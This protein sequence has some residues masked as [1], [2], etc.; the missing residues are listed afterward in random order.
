MG[1][2]TH[3]SFDDF[4]KR[5][6]PPANMLTNAE[7]DVDWDKERNEWLGYLDTLYATIAEFLQEYINDDS[8]R[9][10]F[11]QVTL[12]EEDIGSY[13]ARVMEIYIGRQEITLMP[14][15]TLFIGLKGRV[16][17][18]GSAGRSRLLLVN[19]DAETPQELFNGKSGAATRKVEW[20]WKIASAPPAVRFM[21]LNKVSLFQVL[22]EVS[23]G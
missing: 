2:P 6:Q 17:I 16:D 3:T 13:I 22:M 19:K 10:Q 20:A 4:V 7:A 9:L 15:G 8:I 14:V 1:K 11:E 5:Q 12:N 18:L 23:N 21:E